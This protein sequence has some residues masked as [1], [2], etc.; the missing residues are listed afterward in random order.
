MQFSDWKGQIKW[1]RRTGCAWTELSAVV[2]HG[3]VTACTDIYIA[4][5]NNLH[6][7][8]GDID[9]VERTGF[10]ANIDGC[11]IQAEFCR[12]DAV[13]HLIFADRNVW[14]PVSTGAG[15][16]GVC[17]VFHI[18]DLQVRNRNFG[19]VYCAGRDVT[20]VDG[21][22]A[23]RAEGGDGHIAGEIDFIRYQL[24]GAIRHRKIGR[25]GT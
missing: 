22:F 16:N 14:I 15:D 8:S 25:R 5:A 6:I 10:I 1:I 17:A 13:G 12:T 7:P 21:G 19:C 24:D 18:V 23:R 4:A 9:R 3:I 20:G 2:H 11:P